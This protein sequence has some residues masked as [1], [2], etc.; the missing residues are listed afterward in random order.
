MLLAEEMMAGQKAHAALTVEHEQLTHRLQ[1]SEPEQQLA[2]ENQQRLARVV[3]TQN[4]EL[5]QAEEHVRV[6]ARETD[7]LRADPRELE[8]VKVQR[9]DAV[10]SEEHLRALLKEVIRSRSAEGVGL[11]ALWERVAELGDETSRL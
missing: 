9:D 4:E 7:R 2:L 1:E 11:T 3:Q 5:A 6:R 8:Q 10:Q